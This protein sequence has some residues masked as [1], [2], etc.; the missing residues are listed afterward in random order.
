MAMIEASATQM[1]GQIDE[2]IDM[3][4][5]KAGQPLA[6]DLVDLDVVAL[7]REAIDELAY[8]AG[9]HQIGLST[10]LTSLTGSGDPV[11]LKRVLTNLLTNA[12][13]YSPE[14]GPILIIVKREADAAGS[15]AVI[16][17][18]DHGVGIPAADLPHIFERF[19]RG[20]NVGH[21]PG[22]GLGL[23]GARQVVEQHGGT[24]RV[25]SSEDVGSTFSIRLPLRAG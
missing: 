12:I 21:I 16:E 25:V 1:S 3:A 8:D 6:L 10:V 2:L 13:K 14:G 5:L 9:R 11:R 19:H 15:W 24:L 17:V 22:E 4:R 20:S 23:A 18:Q 7:A